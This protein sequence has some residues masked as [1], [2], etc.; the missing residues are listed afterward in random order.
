[1]LKLLVKSTPLYSLPWG[2]RNN[3]HVFPCITDLAVNI[4]IQ[5]ISPWVI[6]LVTV[7]ATK[8]DCMPRQQKLVV[9]NAGSSAFYSLK[10]VYF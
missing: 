7:E 6:S 9:W 2:K 3:K 1:M 4:W 10:Y 8:A 5:K